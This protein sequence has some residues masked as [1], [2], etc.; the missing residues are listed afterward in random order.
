MLPSVVDPT[1]LPP[2]LLLT[3]LLDQK[4]RYAN[5][6]EQDGGRDDDGDGDA[7][8][9]TRINSA[10]TR[11]RSEEEGPAAS[12]LLYIVLQRSTAPHRTAPRQATSA[13]HSTTVALEIASADVLGY[14]R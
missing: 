7:D 9:S 11:T 14:Y 12:N 1:L 4:Y 10:G 6:D 3:R 5:D 8:D 2:L 13:D